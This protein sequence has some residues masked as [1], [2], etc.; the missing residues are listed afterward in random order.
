[1]NRDDVDAFE[2]VVG[3]LDGLHNEISIM[4]RKSSN[5]GLNTFKLKFVNAVLDQCNI[6][7]GN[8]YSPFPDFKQFDPNE[9]PSN[10]DVTLMLGQYLKAAEKFRSDNIYKPDGDRKWYWRVSKGG[11]VIR[12][13]PPLNLKD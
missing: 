3:Q 5:D 1:M 11:G 8:K 13:H 9:L 7:L 6:I 4:A 12:T 10:S 2:K